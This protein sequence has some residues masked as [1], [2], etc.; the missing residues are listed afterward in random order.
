MAIQ[1]TLQQMLNRLAK[2]LKRD[3][4][5]ICILLRPGKVQRVAARFG[6]EG[7]WIKDVNPIEVFD[8][9][10]K[11]AQPDKYAQLQRQEM[12]NLEMAQ[13]TSQLLSAVDKWVVA[14]PDCTPA[15]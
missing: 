12:A 10:E 5:E 3:D 11:T 15:F 14:K 6:T 4:L 13:K 9:L 2:T 8:L 1:E 7:V